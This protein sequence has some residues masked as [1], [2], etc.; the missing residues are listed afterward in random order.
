MKTN[1]N[2]KLP[3]FQYLGNS[4]RINFNEQIKETQTDEDVF[5][6][7]DYDT[8]VVSKSS[9][10]DER[11]EVIVSVKYPTYGAELAA[12]NGSVEEIYNHSYHVALA[13]YLA[14]KSLGFDVGEFDFVPSKISPRQAKE[15]LIRKG[16]F[17]Q[18]ESSIEAVTDTVEKA[19]LLNY[20]QT[21][22]DFERNN[23]V[24]IQLSESLG[25]SSTDVDDMFKAGALL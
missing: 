24:L 2:E 3:E 21:A 20:W 16:L 4:L 10:L 8:A 13:K 14:K 17:D 5:I 6:S 23:P 9:S 15:V 19:I 1:S 25:M 22:T 7:F 18:V 11:I 12:K